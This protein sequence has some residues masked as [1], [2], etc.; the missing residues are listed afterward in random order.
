MTARAVAGIDEAWNAALPEASPAARQRV[1][2]DVVAR[3]AQEHRVYHGV[4]HLASVV[5]WVQRLGRHCTDPAATVL[6]AFFHDAVYE[7]GDAGNE[8]ASAQLARGSLIEL[9]LDAARVDRV[10]A[11]VVVTADH[12]VPAGAE[13]SADAAVLCDADLAILGESDAAYDRY[14][15][16]VRR[17]YASVPDDLW[18]T[19]RR[20]VLDAFL[21]RNAIYATPPMA[22]ERETAARRNLERERTML[23]G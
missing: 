10:A 1:L 14:V 2:S 9:G 11:L 12:V 23:V 5:G 6:A 4:A 22:E 19:G 20:H 7:I 17:E 16:A 21:Q 15:A 8:A 18:R 13:L 3:Y